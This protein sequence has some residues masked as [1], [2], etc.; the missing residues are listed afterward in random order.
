[1]LHRPKNCSDILKVATLKILLHLLHLWNI[2]QTGFLTDFEKN[3][4]LIA[5]SQA[6]TQFF[7]IF[8]A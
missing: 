4:L 3:G 6:R 5:E 2:G 7:D 8:E 1:M